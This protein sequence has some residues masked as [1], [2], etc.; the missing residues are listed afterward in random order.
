MAQGQLPIFPVGMSLI[1][2][3]IAFE[4]REGTVYYFH[5]MMPLF[6]HHE[7]DL[8]SFRMITSQIV[9]SGV[10]KQIEIVKAFGVSVISVK[11]YVKI[12][13]EKG[14]A[15]F[16]EKKRKRGPHILK[17]EVLAKAQSLLNMGKSVPQAAK[18]LNLKRDT[19]QKAVKAGRLKKGSNFDSRR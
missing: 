18:E 9:D 15:G 12:Y 7:N 1:N 5:G 19:L 14:V 13:R 11:R 16:F 8:A 2:N 17:E 10:A 6:H 3:Q 4:K